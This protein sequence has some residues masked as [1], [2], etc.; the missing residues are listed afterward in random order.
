MVLRFVAPVPSMSSPSPSALIDRARTLVVRMHGVERWAYAIDSAVPAD[1][2]RAAILAA[3]Y[4]L[5]EEAAAEPDGTSQAEVAR[6]EARTD[7]EDPD[8]LVTLRRPDLGLTL[9]QAHGATTPDRLAPVLQTTGFAPQSRLLR[10]AYD[11]GNDE[12]RRA[13]TAL[14]HMVVAWDDDWADL[15]LLHLASPDPIVRHDA[16]LAT[17]VA[18]LCA[19]E[20]EPAC[21]LLEE[22]ARHEKFPKL[23]Q[24]VVEALAAVRN[25]D[26]ARETRDAQ[27]LGR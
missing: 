27:G 2:V 16:I 11:I 5:V 15:F 12:A 14:A 4:V 25:L 1:A 7:R 22:A 6:Y 24:T 21:T 26:G 17:A 23:R 10:Q 9:L 18:A 8:V 20:R 3:G 19:R 13:L